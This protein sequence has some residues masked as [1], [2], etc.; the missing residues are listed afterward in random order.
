MSMLNRI[1]LCAAV[2]LVAVPWARGASEPAPLADLFAERARSV[3]AVEFFIQREIDRQPGESIGVVVDD[4]GLIVLL[5][6][7]LPD[8]MPPSSF[9]D[10]T[11][12]PIAA[13]GESY[14]AQYRGLDHLNDWHFLVVEEAAREL[15]TPITDWSVRAP[16]TGEELWGFG[17]HGANLSFRPYLLTGRH[18][19]DARMP[20]RI[21]LATAPVATPGAPVFTRDGAFAGWADDA[22]TQEFYLVVGG[23]PNTQV[24]G[25]RNFR[26]STAF[27]FA[28]DFLADV[29]RAPESPLDRPQPWVGVAGMQPIEDDVAQFLGLEDRGAVVV[30]EV[31]PGHPAEAAGLQSRDIVIA[32][33]GEPLPKLEPAAAIQEYF[34]RQ[35]LLREPGDDLVFTVIRG[36]AETAVTIPVGE[37]PTQLREAQRS[38]HDLLGVGVREFILADAVRFQVP[39]ADGYGAVVSFVKPNSPADSA[40]LQVGDWVQELDGTRMEDLPAVVT[41]LDAASQPHADAAELVF[42]VKRGNQ[43]A[44]VRVQLP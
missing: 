37:A 27:L 18:S 6:S 39:L 34:S 17:V 28:E 14:A 43:N 41:R 40:G 44:V 5:A 4:A 2:C 16:R 25:L 19:F 31:L 36:E 32:I 13:P 10:F 24:I 23:Q 9:R 21:G 30:S 3:V 38:W 12:S 42:L 20:L 1:F 33:D 11:V 35:I 15:L 29:Q 8:W 7:A 22:L 26:E